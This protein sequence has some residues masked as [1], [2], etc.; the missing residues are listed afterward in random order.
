MY[1]LRVLQ[2]SFFFY[3]IIVFSSHIGSDHMNEAL[4]SIKTFLSIIRKLGEDTW[5]MRDMSQ[6]FDVMRSTKAFLLY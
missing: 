2:A 4:S 1:I 3:P 5:K 6:C